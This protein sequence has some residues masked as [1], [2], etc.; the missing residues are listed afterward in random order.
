MNADVFCVSCVSCPRP[1]ESFCP[2]SCSTTKNWRRGSQTNPGGGNSH[3][4]EFSSWSLPK[5]SNLT[6][7]FFQGGWFNLQ[8]DAWYRVQR[9]NVTSER[10]RILFWNS[11]PHMT[12]GNWKLL[13]HFCRSSKCSGRCPIY[14]WFGCFLKWWYPQSPPQNDHF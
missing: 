7:I 5:W 2:E 8:L 9:L 3:I 13:H 12:S 6:S 4:L 11:A 14:G 1:G 10:P